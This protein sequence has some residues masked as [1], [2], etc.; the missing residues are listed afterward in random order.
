MSG[1]RRPRHRERL[2]A[3]YPSRTSLPGHR[4]ALLPLRSRLFWPFLV[5][6]LCVALAVVLIS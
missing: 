3:G 2:Q 4:W 5:Q 1:N 6:I